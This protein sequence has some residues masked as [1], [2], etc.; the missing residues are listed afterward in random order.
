MSEHSDASVEEQ[1]RSH[2]IDIGSDEVPDVRFTYA[3]E[4]TFWPGTEPSW[5]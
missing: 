3:N 5:R 2:E 4:R 1:R